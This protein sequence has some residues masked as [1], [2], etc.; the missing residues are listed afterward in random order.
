[1]IDDKKTIDVGG[2]SMLDFSSHF[3]QEGTEYFFR[4]RVAFKNGN[5]YQV[6]AMGKGTKATTSAEQFVGSFRLK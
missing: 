1:V 4:G 6:A 5:L 3:T 2:S